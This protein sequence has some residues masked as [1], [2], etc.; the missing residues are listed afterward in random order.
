[1]TAK[2]DSSTFQNLKKSYTL[3][4]LN[5][6]EKKYQLGVGTFAMWLMKLLTVGRHEFFQENTI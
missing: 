6:I 4:H 1:M 2:T 5:T 3:Q